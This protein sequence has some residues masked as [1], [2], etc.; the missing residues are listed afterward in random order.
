[1][2]HTPQHPL[3]F[4]GQPESYLNHR[5]CAHET[6]RG[7]ACMNP[8][9]RHYEDRYRSIPCAIHQSDAYK[10]ERA[11][12]LEK[13]RKRPLEWQTPVMTSAAGEPLRTDIPPSLLDISVTL[14]DPSTGR[15]ATSPA[16]MRQMVVDYQTRNANLIMVWKGQW[17][18]DAFAITAKE[19][20]TRLIKPP[21][22]TY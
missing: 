15:F 16:G 19:A 14:I 5:I 6:T 2:T 7:T 8:A 1:M 13:E 9:Q 17:R 20:H 21:K 12:Y 10:T 4:P 3:K 18:S 22:R 11:L